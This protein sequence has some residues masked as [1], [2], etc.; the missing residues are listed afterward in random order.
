M[1]AMKVVTKVERKPIMKVELNDRAIEKLKVADFNFTYVAKDGSTKTKD[2]IILPIKTNKKTS[3]KGL[4]LTIH[5]STGS[6]IFMI[7]YK[8]QRKTKTLILG[9]FSLGTFGIKQVEELLFPIVKAHTN[10]RGHWIKD[11]QIT[12]PKR[13]RKNILVKDRKSKLG[14]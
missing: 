9:K 11:P 7:K 6:K 3:L 1:E 14:G 2:R 5:R 8:F 12:S 13:H 4:K 10:E